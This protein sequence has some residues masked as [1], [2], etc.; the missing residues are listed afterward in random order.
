MR[1]IQSSGMEGDRESGRVGVHP[2]RAL[3][4]MAMDGIANG[5]GRPDASVPGELI[6]S[7]ALAW[8]HP[9]RDGV[10]RRGEEAGRAGQVRSFSIAIAIDRDLA[11]QQETADEKQR[12]HADHPTP[13][14]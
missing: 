5:H 11:T 8:D 10:F 9:L 14:L 12:D 4:A 13:D 1:L 6:P 2:S 3:G 7:R